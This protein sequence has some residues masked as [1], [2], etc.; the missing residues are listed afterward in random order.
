MIEAYTIGISLA[1]DS[2]VGEGLAAIR[3]DLAAVDEATRL[4]AGNLEQLKQA[5][6]AM[7]AA[8]EA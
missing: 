7:P 8:A 4:A 2:G 3:Q 6:A 5:A 1:L